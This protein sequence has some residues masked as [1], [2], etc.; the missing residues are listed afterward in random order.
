MGADQQPFFIP[1][2]GSS[3]Y[4]VTCRRLSCLFPHL[5]ECFGNFALHCASRRDTARSTAL[6][7][8][9]AVHKAGTKV[10]AKGAAAHISFYIQCHTP[11]MA[12][13]GSV[14]ELH[15]LNK[16]PAASEHVAHN[17]YPF[18]RGSDVAVRAWHGEHCDDTTDALAKLV[19]K[20]GPA[21]TSVR[22][23]AG[24]MRRCARVGGATAAALRD[25]ICSNML[26]GY[27]HSTASSDPQQHAALLS[28][29]TVELAEY[30]IASKGT[31]QLHHMVAEYVC[32]NTLAND[33]L[34]WSV[35]H[36][37]ARH[38]MCVAEG[39][40]RIYGKGTLPIAPSNYS[41]FMTLARALNVNAGVGAAKGAPSLD[42]ARGARGLVAPRAA[43]LMNHGATR[44]D[45]ATMHICFDA[46]SNFTL[47]AMRAQIKTMSRPA[48]EFCRLH[49][50]SALQACRVRSLPFGALVRDAQ[51]NALRRHRGVEWMTVPL[52]TACHTL[53]VAVAGMPVNKKSLGTA[54]CLDTSAI[55][56]NACSSDAVVPVDMVGR[57]LVI[58]AKRFDK[59]QKH[60]SRAIA[61][62]CG[63]GGLTTYTELFGIYPLCTDCGHRARRQ[64][65][66]ARRCV[67]GASVE[68]P[69]STSVHVTT[70]TGGVEEAALCPKHAHLAPD[71]PVTLRA[72][73]ALVAAHTHPE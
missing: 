38:A 7:R 50:W 29:T 51:A 47:K 15:A 4:A 27:A 66:T 33:A 12:F 17:S 45:V 24:L 40:L 30:A 19:R 21:P 14:R 57:R 1:R 54:T 63:C 69:A 62:C 70:D 44:A 37:A 67:C 18:T 59:A 56:C 6:Y 64:M 20:G 13:E 71:A 34:V 53:R 65:R 60:R 5:K 26:G 46:R 9:A 32:A 42:A 43:A 11:A 2:H 8:T 55:H 36:V 31:K 48:V 52:C 25:M 73:K 41:M 58:L 3:K 39:T 16:H 10:A 23:V 61:V 28:M 68:S 35:G 22:Y 72:I 49:V